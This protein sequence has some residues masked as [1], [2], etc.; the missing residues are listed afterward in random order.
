MKES[1]TLGKLFLALSKFQ[2]EVPT[3]PKNTQGYG[4]KYCSLADM[5][6]ICTPV[7]AKHELCVTQSNT[8][9]DGMIAVETRLGHSSGEFISDVMPMNCLAQKG[10]NEAQAT[11]TV[12]SYLRRYGY[13]SILCVASEE[14]TDGTGT[15]A[16]ASE[17]K[18]NS[19]TASLKNKIGAPNELP[20]QRLCK[21]IEQH[22]LQD[23]LPGWLAHYSVASIDDLSAD[24]ALKLIKTIEVKL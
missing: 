11:G 19:I 8:R 15:M 24:Q 2:N 22:S 14:D 9:I 10:M 13:A 12:I 21:L 18:P 23:K 4:Y 3:I 20:I 7:L 17:D 16:K 6:S 5:I 1:P